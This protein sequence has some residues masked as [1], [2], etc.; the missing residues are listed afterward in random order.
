MGR[1]DHLNANFSTADP[2]FLSVFRALGDSKH[3]YKSYSVLPDFV[4]QELELAP[5]NTPGYGLT[6]R[7]KLGKIAAIC[8]SVAL[9]FRLGALVPNDPATAPAPSPSLSLSEPRFVNFV[10][11][12]M[13][14]RAEVRLGPN[15]LHRIDFTQLFIQNQLYS[16]EA[17]VIAQNEMAAG[18]LAG[19]ATGP[20][21]SREA[22]AT[23]V[24][25]CTVNLPFWFDELDDK[26]VHIEGL[27]DTLEFNITFPR[28]LDVVD[29]STVGANQPTGGALSDVVLRF[30]LI[31]FSDKERNYHIATTRIDDGVLML[32]HEF[33]YQPAQAVPLTLEMRYPLRNLRGPTYEIRWIV[34][35]DADVEGDLTG[36]K[37]WFNYLSFALGAAPGDEFWFLE[38]QGNQVIER[39][40]HQWNL[41]AENSKSHSNHPGRNIYGYSFNND[42]EDRRNAVGHLTLAGITNPEIIVNWGAVPGAGLR[43][44]AIAMEYNVMSARKG[45]LQT[46]IS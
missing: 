37:D 30:S 35:N 13:A 1:K 8:S 41:F 15:T 44:S 27:G 40:D 26:A 7:W 42:T 34:Q 39:M 21:D 22:R 14:E 5:E 9:R 46:L 33:K 24:Q 12:R 38:S 36:R 31:H 4:K 43:I 25:K 19:G 17:Q 28:F 2:F 3:G 32:F 45:S 16:E 29:V 11:Y 6:G 10:G 20:G 23:R 18:D